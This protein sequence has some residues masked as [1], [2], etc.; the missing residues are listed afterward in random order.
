MTY[1]ACLPGSAWDTWR[2]TGEKYK[3]LPLEAKE[4]AARAF[5]EEWG[6]N[7]SPAM[8]ARYRAFMEGAM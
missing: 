6:D 4:K 1:S 2:K 3:G 7:R 8:E 5:A